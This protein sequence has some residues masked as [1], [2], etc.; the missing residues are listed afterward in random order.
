MLA[1]ASSVAANAFVS[2]ADITWV[3]FSGCP[4]CVGVS[5]F[6]AHM[7]IF[8]WCFPGLMEQYTWNPKNMCKKRVQVRL[9]TEWIQRLFITNEQNQQYLIWYLFLPCDNQS[10]ILPPRDSAHLKLVSTENSNR[11]WVKSYQEGLIGTLAEG[12]VIRAIDWRLTGELWVKLTHVVS[13]LLQ[14]QKRSRTGEEV[15]QHEQMCKSVW[16]RRWPG[17]DSWNLS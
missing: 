1:W 3:V 13:W 17:C 6:L 9:R 8:L 16:N 2:E 4:W 11:S 10:P 14:R 7:R 15:Q 5:G 12:R